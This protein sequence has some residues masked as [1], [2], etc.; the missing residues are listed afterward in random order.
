MLLLLQITAALGFTGINVVA[1]F[2]NNI[3]YTNMSDNLKRLASQIWRQS[4][5]GFL[6][7]LKFTCILQHCGECWRGCDWRCPWGPCS[8]C[9]HWGMQG[10]CPLQVS[11]EQ[12]VWSAQD[13]HRQRCHDWW[14]QV[15]VFNQWEAY[16]PFR[17][18]F[19]LQWVHCHACWLC[20]KDQSWGSPW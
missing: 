9:V 11:W 4:T 8:S 10:V 5:G 17:W 16:L 14:W 20:C 19:H 15:T 7:P 18:D 12:H 13:Q 3:Y 6:T 1:R 2:T